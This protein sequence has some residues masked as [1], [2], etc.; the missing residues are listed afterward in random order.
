M[1][2]LSLHVVGADFPNRGGGNRRFEIL[3]CTPG[4]AAVLVPEPRNPVDPHAVMVVS[5]RGVQIGYLTADRAAW[6]GAMLRQGRAV[7]ALFQ[8]ATP[9]GAA[10]RVAFDGAVPVLPGVQV[11]DVE[12]EPD[13]WPDDVPP[14]A[15]D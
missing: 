5:A 14:D 1:R 10:I 6:I 15:W 7:A 13:F 9:M 11:V 4:E 8:Q 2:E 12:P 3:L